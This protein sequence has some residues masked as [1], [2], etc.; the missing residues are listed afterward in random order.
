VLRVLELTL[1]S[2]PRVCEAQYIPRNP[3]QTVLY[4]VIAEQ[5]ETFLARRQPTEAAAACVQ[6]EFRKYLTCGLAEHGFLR[7]HCDAECF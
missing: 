5:L 3:E 1:G 2:A 7:L 6:R 4:Q